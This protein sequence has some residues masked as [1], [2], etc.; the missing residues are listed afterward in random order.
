MRGHLSIIAA[1]SLS[2]LLLVGCQTRPGYALRDVA[3][4]YDDFG[5]ARSLTLSSP[6]VRTSFL[7]N[8]TSARWYDGRR[9]IGPFVT[10]GTQS[11]RHEESVTFTRDSQYIYGDRVYDRYNE[12]THRRT[13]RSSTR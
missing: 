10:S 13:Y 6:V 12:T 7:P 5:H 3:P 8:D 2:A 1:L 4:L 11:L 9:D